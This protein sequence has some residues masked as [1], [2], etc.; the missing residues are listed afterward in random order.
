MY[1]AQTYQRVML[2]DDEE[3][4][5]RSFS[6]L[7]SDRGFDVTTVETGEGAIS[8][9]S[10]HAVDVVVSDLRMPGMDGMQLLQWV[11][12]KSPKTPFILLTGYG[13][14]EVERRAK[15]LGAYG[16]LNKPISPEQLSAV[17]TAASLMSKRDE[18]A[19]LAA[20][21]APVETAQ[22]D[23]ALAVEAEAASAVEAE[24]ATELVR[25][26]LVAAPEAAPAKKTR[27]ARSTAQVVAG[28]TLAPIAGLAFV[29][30]LPVIGIG[31]LCW[32]VW[33]AISKRS[34]PARA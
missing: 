12:E 31:A 17:I 24:A 10:D 13:N 14:E 3:G 16:L 8:Q 27:R 33:E 32:V 25:T 1:G 29:M 15:E 23:A 34:T 5:R 18:A 2:V 9:L 6:R 26:E 11:H 30:F 28:L 20:E 4:V 19:K 7:L 22:A 21:Q